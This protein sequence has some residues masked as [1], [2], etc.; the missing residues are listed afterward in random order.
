MDAALD[1]LLHLAETDVNNMALYDVFIKGILDYLDNLSLPQIR[2]LF[3]I[4]SLLALTSSDKDNDGSHSS[5]WSEIQIVIRKQLS[6]PREKYKKIGVVGCLAIIKVLGSDTL[7]NS[8]SVAESS[9][10]STVSVQQANRHPLLRQSIQML[11]MI[12]RNC[13]EYPIC[14]ALMYDELAY[15]VEYNN[16]DKRLQLWIKENFTDCFTEDYVVDTESVEQVIKDK[17]KRSDLCLKPQNRIGLDDE[18]EESSILIGLYP[19][20]CSLDERQKRR[21]VLTL[22]PIFNLIQTYE[23]VSNNN[24]LEEIDALLGCAI[25]LFKWDEGDIQDLIQDLPPNEMQDACD[26]LFYTI[27]WLRELLNAFCR[28]NDEDDHNKL[29]MRIK[30]I[31]SLEALLEQFIKSMGSY[32]PLEFHSVTNVEGKDTMRSL[33]SISSSSTPRSPVPDASNVDPKPT[34]K[35]SSTIPSF[36][37][38]NALRPF[39]RALHV[40]VV[41]ILDHNDNS[42]EALEYDEIN[43][44]LN[45]LYNKLV[46]KVVPMPATPFGRKKSPDDKQRYQNQASYLLRLNARDLVKQVVTHLP[47]I[48]QRLENLYEDIQLQDTQAGRFNSSSEP[49]VQCASA[50]FNIIHK[51]FSWPDIGNPENQDILEVIFGLLAD[52]LAVENTQSQS[53]TTK[54]QEAFKYLARFSDNMPEASTAVVLFKTLM[55][56]RELSEA[57]DSLKSNAHSVVTGILKEDWF[58]WRNIK[59]EIPYL[60]EQAIELDQDPLSTLHSY[61]DDVLENFEENGSLDEHPLLRTDTVLSYYQAMIN[62]TVKALHLLQETHQDASVI[63]VQNSQIVKIFWNIT[64]YTKTKDQRALFGMILKTGRSF[65][66]QFA[67]HSIPFFTN[68]FRS[69]K[70]EIV[71]IL[72]VFQKSTRMLQIICSHVKV[73]KDVQLS[74]YVPPLKRSLEIV[75]FQVKMLL[76]EN[77]APSDAFFMGALKHRD[78]RGEEVQSQLPREESDDEADELNSDRMNSDDMDTDNENEDNENGDSASLHRPAQAHQEISLTNNN[79]N[80]NEFTMELDFDSATDDEQSN[81]DASPPVIAIRDDDDDDIPLKMIKRDDVPKKKSSKEDLVPRKKQRIGMGRPNF[82]KGKVF[83]LTRDE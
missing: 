64:S 59:K 76:T 55:R 39:M 5:L 2:T 17:N 68:V 33:H 69:H 18:D 75:I 83:S 24:N 63:L 11:E 32:T 50:I 70:N 53:F 57:G 22:C 6:N 48:L 31:L 28:S 20:V 71:D 73:I 78:I 19:I 79:P 80:D 23:R 26:M 61:V 60:L 7:C 36:D 10:Q 43:Y 49:I 41:A 51:L 29:I 42:Q 77:N 1:V 38:V 54:A 3:N 45:D 52:R 34:L 58:D 35:K 44:I 74:S 8:T 21:L 40:D 62:Q 37:S 15:M 46:K 9:T 27:N 66:D 30:N 81:M 12:M 72:K 13:A 47:T 14:L 56:I 82:S 25:I 67:K 4:F 65:V 16:L